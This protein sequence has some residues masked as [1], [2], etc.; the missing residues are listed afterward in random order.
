MITNLDPGRLI[1]YY[2]FYQ[3]IDFI[4][5]IWVFVLPKLI[6]TITTLSPIWRYEKKIII[7]LEIRNLSHSYSMLFLRR[8]T[9]SVHL[10]FSL[11]RIK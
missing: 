3:I 6:H 9:P 7:A 10:N 4:Y 8:G 2:Y 1:S 5:Q 11:S